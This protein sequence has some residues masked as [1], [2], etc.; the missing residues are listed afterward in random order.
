MTAGAALEWNANWLWSLPLI[1]LTVTLHVIGLGFINAS[2]LKS[3]ESVKE[4]RHFLFVFALVTGAATLSA[5][6]L[7][8]IEAVAWAAAYLALGALPDH[9][10]A[11]LYSLGAMTTYGHVGLFLAPHWRLM[12]ALEALNG[13]LLFGLTTAFLYGMIQAV[14]PVEKRR[15]RQPNLASQRPEKALAAAPSLMVATEGSGDG[16]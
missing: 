15:L 13:M 16:A 1:A 2:I 11:M 7:H 9:K 12:G 6:L 8:A 5:T 4:R 3:L 10:S 14:W